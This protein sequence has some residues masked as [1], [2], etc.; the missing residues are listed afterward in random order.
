MKALCYGMNCVT[1]PPPNSYVEVL[2]PGPQNVSI[3]GDRA[4]REMIKLT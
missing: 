4:F 3:F 1:P 2:D